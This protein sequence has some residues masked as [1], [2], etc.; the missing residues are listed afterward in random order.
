[1]ASLEGQGGTADAGGITVPVIIEGPWHDLKYRPDLAG[2]IGDV[3][4]DPTKALEGAKD[5]V[6]KL[7]EGGGVE[8]VLKGIVQPPAGDTEQGGG[9]IPD[10]KKVLK[11]LFGD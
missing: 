4:K 7:K 3:A 9:L 5:T 8:E 10:P 11:G 6:K 1:M 2:M